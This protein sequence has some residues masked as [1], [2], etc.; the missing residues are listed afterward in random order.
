MIHVGLQNLRKVYAN[1]V[2]AI[3]GVTL[4]I[5]AGQCL[6]LVGPSGCGKTTLLRVLA[7]LEDPSSGTIAFDGKVVNQVPSNRRDVAIV[8]QRPALVLGRSVRDNL[9]WSWTLREP[10]PLGVIRGVVGRPRHT[11][12]QVRELADVADRLGLGQVL[13]R[14]AGELSG[15]QQQR[16]A[17]GRAL[18][19]RAALCLLDEPLGHLDAPLRT[20]LRR[21]LRLLSRRFP[22]TM[23]HVTHDPAEALAVGD[24]VAVLHDGRLQQVAPAREVLTRPA[25]R[26]VAAYCR[27]QGPLNFLDGQLTSDAGVESLELA[28]WLRLPVPEPMRSRL[29]GVRRATVGIAPEEIKILPA[30]PAD[31]LAAHIISMEVALAEFAPEGVWV[32]CRREGV[33][34]TGLCSTTGLDSRPGIMVGSNVMIAITLNSAFWFDAVTGVT[35][36]TPAG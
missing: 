32:A 18:L 31:L 12:E 7:G 16:V 22:A 9:A 2:T 1:G 36:A 28:P 30:P 5:P 4:D 25:N 20:Q 34:L 6:A 11:A 21:D 19:R 29:V 8:F 15:G 3:D 35:L 14:P 10:G 17:L 23:V 33:Q 13:E 24:R 27:P 26:F